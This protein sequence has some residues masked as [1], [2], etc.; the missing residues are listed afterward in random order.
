MSGPPGS[1][2]TLLAK[3]LTTI[4][5]ELSREESLEVSKV[6]SVAGKLNLDKP[7]LT[8]RPFRSPHHTA[9]GVSLIGGGTVPAQGKFL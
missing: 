8:T 9:S 2:K 7:L 3:T 4:L 6:Y 5:P 1:G